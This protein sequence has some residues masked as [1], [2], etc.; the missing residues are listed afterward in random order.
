MIQ[1][2][3]GKKRKFAHNVK[4]GVDQK[5]LIP[6]QHTITNIGWERK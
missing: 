5:V 2:H 4:G 1:E 3:V 6:D